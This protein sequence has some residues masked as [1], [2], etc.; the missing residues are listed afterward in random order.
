MDSLKVSLLDIL[1]LLVRLSVGNCASLNKLLPQI[2]S[3]ETR[4]KTFHRDLMG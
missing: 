1:V 3:S 4:A 2:R